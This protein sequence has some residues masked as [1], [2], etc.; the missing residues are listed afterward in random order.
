MRAIVAVVSL[1]V[2]VGCAAPQAKTQG[3]RAPDGPIALSTRDFLDYVTE[4]TADRLVD[5]CGAADTV[6]QATCFK[7]NVLAGFDETG[8]ARSGCFAENLDRDE[9][10]CV[11]IGAFADSMARSAKLDVVGP[12]D[13]ADP[14][15]HFKRVLKEIANKAATQC[16]SGG[17]ACVI[18]RMAGL[19]SL[20]EEQSKS[21][22][23]VS[24]QRKGVSC[25][26]HT[27]LLQVV[28]TA[29]DRMGAAQPL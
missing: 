6:Q 21:C 12:V 18:G 2:L 9:Y 23:A 7:E 28:E 10:K 15:E 4:K 14:T 11:M 20:S 13:W 3:A 24:T 17:C 26:V 8:G 25:V 27:H 29:L 16:G 19:L 1:M 5:I 22:V